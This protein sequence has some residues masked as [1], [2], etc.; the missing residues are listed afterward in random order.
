MERV[1]T[2]GIRPDSVQETEQGDATEQEQKSVREV[3]KASYNTNIFMRLRTEIC[4]A[5]V[6]NY[7]HPKYDSSSKLVHQNYLSVLT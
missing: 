3:L 2:S 4:S 6:S 7:S 5:D 1:R